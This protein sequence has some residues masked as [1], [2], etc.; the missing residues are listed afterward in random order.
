MYLEWGHK[1]AHYDI[2]EPISKGGMSE[3]YRAKDSNLSRDVVDVG[4]E[5]VRRRS[6]NAC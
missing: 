6:S 4:F 5:A 2:V 3:I 1:L